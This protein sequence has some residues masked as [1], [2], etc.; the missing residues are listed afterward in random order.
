VSEPEPR[1]VEEEFWQLVVNRD[2]HVL[3]QQGSI[4]TGDE[5][6]GFPT[7]RSSSCGRHAWNLKVRHC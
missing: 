2:S 3:V 4:D 1:E 5:G 6:Y 7:A